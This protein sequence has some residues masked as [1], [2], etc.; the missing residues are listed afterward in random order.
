MPAV[1]VLAESPNARKVPGPRGYPLIGVLPQVRNNPL[2][3]FLDVARDYGDVVKLDVGR[4]RLLMVN[5]PEYIGHILQTNFHNYRK[6]KFYEKLKPMLGEGF[7]T[8]E[9]DMWLKQRR[10]AQPAFNGPALA[11]ASEEM[12]LATNEMLENWRDRCKQGTPFDICVEMMHLTIDIAARTLF[13]TR[14]SQEQA[15]TAYE[16]L[17]LIL[18]EAERK[19]WSLFPIPLSVPT[20]RNRAFK[21][22]IK[23]IEDL[24][25]EIVGNRRRRPTPKSDLLSM[26][27]KVYGNENDPGSFRML[28]DLVISILMAG[29]ETTAAALA[30]TFSLLSAHPEVERRVYAEIMAAIGHRRPTYGDLQGLEYTRAVFE[31]S[32]RLYPPV[33]TISRT[34][35]DAD[36]IGDFDI[37]AG[38]SIML[39]IY[40]VHR[41]PKL[42]PNPDQFD[43]E[44]F[45]PNARPEPPRYAY[46]PFGGGPRVCIASRF[47]TMEALIML[48]MIIREFKV[49]LVPGQIEPEPM[50]TL[51]PRNGMRVHLRKR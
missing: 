21:T 17:T 40:A 45:L 25:L 38:S 51:R 15:E 2:K 49:E 22:A 3:F 27:L 8:S 10:L 42:W 48:A 33:W 30:W 7:L 14:L 23:N 36:R 29:H 44:R 6:S 24:F 11:G 12:A 39:C 20:T 18:R 26:I 32:L 31:E 1:S 9:G 4:D 35:I 16:A 13:G 43:P 37:P 34:A 28:R 46:F 50:I 19:I 5:R 47:A 41:D